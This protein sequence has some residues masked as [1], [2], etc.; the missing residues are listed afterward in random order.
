M[1]VRAL[2]ERGLKSE[3]DR[4][5]ARELDSRGSVRTD[6]KDTEASQCRHTTDRTVKSKQTSQTATSH[7]NICVSQ[8][9]GSR[10]KKL[11]SLAN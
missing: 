10:E 7:V 6:V 11:Q 4:N 2:E 9:P 5:P 1:S 8:F 3:L